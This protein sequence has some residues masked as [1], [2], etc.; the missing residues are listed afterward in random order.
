MNTPS[1][2]YSIKPTPLWLTREW[3]DFFFLTNLRPYPSSSLC[4]CQPSL[5]KHTSSRNIYG[6]TC[7]LTAQICGCILKGKTTNIFL[8]KHRTFPASWHVSKTALSGFHE[9]LMLWACSVIPKRPRTRVLDQWEPVDCCS[10]HPH[11]LLHASLRLASMVVSPGSSASLPSSSLYWV[12]SFK[13]FLLD[14]HINITSLQ[15]CVCWCWEMGSL[16]DYRNLGG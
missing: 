11:P 4:R 10:L 12:D 7:V 13:W 5:L 6:M 16:R 9:A 14:S 15:F 3:D 8:P 1:L 2:A